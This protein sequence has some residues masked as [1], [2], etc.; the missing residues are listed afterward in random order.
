M[1][2]FFPVA[3]PRLNE[4]SIA[5]V[6]D[7]VESHWISSSGKYLQ[8]FETSFSENFGPGNSICVSNGTMAIELALIAL[9]IGPGDE[10]IVP[11]FTFVGSVSPIYRV[12][13]TPVLVP[14]TREG[15][16][17]DP[18]A[19][20]KAI[21]PKT[22]AIIA[23]HLYGHPC[24]IQ[25]IMAIAKEHQLSVVEDCA[26][27]LGA[28]V[29]GQNIGTFGDVG[30]YSFFGNKVLTTGE[31]G[32][33]ITQCPELAEKIEIY[34]NHGMRKD[35]RYWHRVI[36]YNGR[37]TNL[38]AAVGFGQLHTIQQ[39]LTRRMEIQ[40]RYFKTL[41]PTGF[42]ED[43]PLPQ[44]TEPVNWLTSPLLK[45]NMG[46]DRDKL[47]TM[48]K[49]R[50]I[51]SRPFFY[52]VS[53]MPA[54]SRFGFHDQRSHT[55]ASHGFNLP[56]YIDLQDQE[57]DH[58]AKNVVECCKTLHSKHG[59]K[60]FALQLP[61]SATPLDQP[62][63]SVI[64]PTLNAGESILE[65]VTVLREQMISI[66]HA[67]EILIMD[68]HSHDGSIQKLRER[69]EHDPLIKIHARVEKAS[70][71]K[72]LLD[73]I[74]LSAG[75]IILIMDANG[76]HDPHIASQ[77]VKNAQDFDAVSASRFTA[78][79]YCTDPVKQFFSKNFNRILRLVLGIPTRDNTSG[80]LCIKKE[81]LLQ[82]DPISAFEHGPNYFFHLI[83]RV[84]R[85]A[86]S[87][88]EIPTIYRRPFP[89]PPSRR[90]LSRFFDYG[91][92]AVQCLLR[93]WLP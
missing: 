8:N 4:H 20:A 24:D 73:G 69:F 76:N 16:N 47:L 79:G 75:K 93:R 40:E 85:R 10:V 37:M 80:Y 92:S 31:G 86:W 83:I 50:N 59:S 52:P 78:G 26:E 82:L 3:N 48:L 32:L 67:Y 5:F 57:I 29:N 27:A 44:N 84:H 9:G 87:I 7:C 34:K 63:V 11:N 12:H 51:D 77:L 1:N 42:F 35:E 28:K 88:L 17:M 45:T 53:C 74:E 91:T 81:K 41:A 6:K 33:C 38:Q 18:Q 15:W 49:D 61:S 68:D 72:A 64:L 13:G 89:W 71:G 56:T 58:I 90:N 65:V 21:T 19:V 46:M 60:T 36:G 62:V 25:S 14:P 70:F 30:C 23:V 39:D 66:S 2:T 22:K 55:L 54:F 43:V